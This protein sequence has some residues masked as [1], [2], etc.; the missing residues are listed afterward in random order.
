[1][2][3]KWVDFKIIR[4]HLGFADVLAHYGIN[5]Q[6]SGHQ[7][8]VL[9]PFHDDHKPS[10]GVNLEKGVYNCFACGAGGN[11][12]DFVAHMEGLDPDNTTELRKAALLAAKT[13]GIEQATVK[14]K[15]QAKKTGKTK[16]TVNASA[17]PPRRPKTPARRDKNPLTRVTCL[18]AKKPPLRAKLTL[19]N[20]LAGK[21]NQ[22]AINR[23]RSS[24]I[25]NASTPSSRR[26]ANNWV[27]IKSSSKSLALAMQTKA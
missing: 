19:G 9:C 14:P 21:P 22:A 7:V 12:L 23:L 16:K 25:L 18:K 8:K 27:L 5:Y 17:K 10:L 2:T 4:Q 26:G 11:A 13:F 3:A 24:L 1:M 15:K 20:R 6:A